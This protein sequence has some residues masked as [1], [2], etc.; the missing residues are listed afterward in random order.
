MITVLRHASLFVLLFADI[1][2]HGA[3][4]A[5]YPGDSGRRY[6]S[7]QYQCLHHGSDGGTAHRISTALPK[8]HDFHPIITVSNRAP[9]AVVLSWVRAF[10]MLVCQRWGC[11]GVSWVKATGKTPLLPAF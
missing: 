2:S 8:G 7:I 11:R 1:L 4:Q 5:Q 9:P 10:A 6:R 3:G